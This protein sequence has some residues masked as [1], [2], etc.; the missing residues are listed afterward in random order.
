[1]YSPG[2]FVASP[3]GGD[4][5]VTGI[6]ANGTLTLML[7]T[8]LLVA[9][10]PNV[11]EITLYRG[12][13]YRFM[14]STIHSLHF[15]ARIGVGASERFQE[16]VEMKPGATLINVTDSMPALLELY[17]E[18]HPGMRALV[19]VTS[20]PPP[21]ASGHRRRVVVIAVVASTAAAAVLAAI[22]VG[23]LFGVR[24]AQRRRRRS[25]I[26]K[27]TETKDLLL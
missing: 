25:K 8:N 11:G 3:A 20:Q 22:G 26:G 2:V 10:V 4:I 24:Q 14:Y 13:S 12:A 18:P 15:T 21:A 17:C 23:I 6:S 9:S 19:R 1:V 7:G 5:L 27:R 16:S